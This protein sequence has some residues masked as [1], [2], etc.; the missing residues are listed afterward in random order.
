MQWNGKCPSIRFS[1]SVEVT[2]S[3]KNGFEIAWCL[4]LEAVGPISNTGILAHVS[5]GKA[6]DMVQLRVH[7][8]NSIYIGKAVNIVYFVTNDGEAQ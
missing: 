2:Q 4:L 6:P 1:S 5:I 3:I 8:S 7:S